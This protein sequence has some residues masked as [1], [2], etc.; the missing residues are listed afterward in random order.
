MK[1]NNKIASLIES[2]R[3]FKGKLLQLYT[4]TIRLKNGYPV[5]LETIKHPGA[6]LIIPFLSK[7]RIV[8]LKQ[9]RPV[10]KRFIYEL[11]AGTLDGKE[12]MVSCARREIEEETGF[13]ANRIKRLGEVYPVPGYST[14]RIVIFKAENLRKVEVM[15]EIDEIISNRVLTKLEV[16]SLFRRGKIVDAKTICALAFCGWL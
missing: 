2:K 12:G 10:I 6:A 15:P 9:F 8:F 1:K 3:I 16:K 4:Q 7:D 14:E 11:P 13:R 5:E